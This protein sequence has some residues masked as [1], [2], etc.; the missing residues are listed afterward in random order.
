MQPCKVK[1][2]IFI[3]NFELCLKKIEK[4][5]R[6]PKRTDYALDNLVNKGGQNLMNI[7]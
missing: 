1:V 5:I 2:T 6:L 3:K 4:N 7:G